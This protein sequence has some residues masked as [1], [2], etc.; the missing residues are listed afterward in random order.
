MDLAF[1][2]CRSDIY[3]V[4]R[5]IEEPV[6]AKMTPMLPI[7]VDDD[8]VAHMFQEVH[9]APL[10]D[11]R[12]ISLDANS[13]FHYFYTPTGPEAKHLASD[14]QN[15]CWKQYL[16]NGRLCRLWNDERVLSRGV[17]PVLFP[18][19]HQHVAQSCSRCAR[20]QSQTQAWPQQCKINGNLG[21]QLRLRSHPSKLSWTT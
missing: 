6:L 4:S 21:T 17:P 18:G 14:F 11:W 5:N 19:I 13:R 7:S 8:E 12:F 3:A 15:V 2:I 9:T 20:V 16:W 1:L 10:G